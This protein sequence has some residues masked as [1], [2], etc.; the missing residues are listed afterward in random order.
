MEYLCAYCVALVPVEE[1]CITVLVEGLMPH[2]HIRQVLR[3]IRLLVKSMD[4]P[5]NCILKLT[6]TRIY[7]CGK[8]FRHL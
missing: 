7:R 4:K 3:D 6:T 8:T 1:R 2:V 5:L